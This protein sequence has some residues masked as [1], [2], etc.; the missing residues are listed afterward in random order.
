MI[1]IFY[2]I[3][4]GKSLNEILPT[5]S[6][7]LI[8]GYKLIPAIQGI[9]TGYAS[10]KGNQTA[11]DN[12]IEDLKDLSNKYFVN[13]KSERLEFNK[14]NLSN[15]S[16]SYGSKEIIENIDIEI[17]KN[18]FTGIIGKTGVG[19]STL[20]NIISGLL[21]PT[22]GEIKIDGKNLS[23][24]NKVKLLNVIGYVP[25]KISLNDDTILSNIAIG[26]SKSDIDMNKIKHVSNISQLDEFVKK[27]PKKFDTYVG[28]DG[29]LLSGGQIQRIGLARALY[30]EP[31]LLIIDEGTSGLDKNTQNN[32]INSL[33]NF[34]NDL[35]VLIVTHRNEILEF[36]DQVYKL[37]DKKIYKI[38]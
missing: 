15:V 36:C 22:A 33:K 8:A 1:F 38:R 20:I 28:E 14:I 29:I 25:Q 17:K 3:N 30:I 18:Q 2:K 19:K 11:I 31:S 35:S 23:H 4:I 5:L 6:I 37:E 13:Q 21:E 32:L 16:F 26:V 24:K 12:T 7:Y 9:A 10:I 34:T 27:L